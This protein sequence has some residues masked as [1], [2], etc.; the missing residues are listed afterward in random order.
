MQN[1]FIIFLIIFM[2][3]ASA[4]PPEN[5]YK[6]QNSTEH[7]MKVT[8]SFWK[9]ASRYALQAVLQPFECLLVHKH[10]HYRKTDYTGHI[11]FTMSMNHLVIKKWIFVPNSLILEINDESAYESFRGLNLFN[12]EV[13]GRANAILG[14]FDSFRLRLNE[15]PNNRNNDTDDCRMFLPEEALFVGGDGNTYLHD[16]VL[17]GDVEKADSLIQNGL[18]ISLKNKDGKTAMDLAHQLE[19][20]EMIS[21]LQKYSGAKPTVD[22]YARWDHIRLLLENGVEAY[23]SD[24]NEI[25]K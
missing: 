13:T 8:A 21:L 5:F 24:T 7:D 23:I 4:N 11:K 16:A 19:D 20:L 1:I 25:Y 22:E 14:L 10:Y 9:E 2:W 12:Y 18:E 6:I 15:V 3:S 17:D